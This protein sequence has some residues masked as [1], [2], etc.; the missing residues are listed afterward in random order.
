MQDDLFS[1]VD[2]ELPSR[3][4]RVLMS[5]EP[6]S[7]GL[8]WQGRKR[9]EFRR[10]YPTGRPTAWYVYLNAPVAKLAAVIDLDAPVVDTPRRIADLAEEACEGNGASV[11]DYL[12][13][14]DFGFAIPIRRV[15]EYPGFTAEELAGRLGA[16]HPPEGYTFVGAHPRLGCVCDS[17]TADT[18][19]RELVVQHPASVS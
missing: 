5:L 11:Y 14:L 12:C 7:Y 9:H 15:R 17:L 13:D 16:F 8:V 3:P 10:D 18:V 4:E 1:A 6:E 2:L 19:A